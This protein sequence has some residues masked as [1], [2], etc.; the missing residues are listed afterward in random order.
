VNAYDPGAHRD[1]GRRII[2]FLVSL[3]IPGPGAGHFVFGRWGTGVGWFVVSLLALLSTPVTGVIGPMLFLGVRLVAAC[4]CVFMGRSRILYPGWGQVL[5]GWAALLGSTLVLGIVA[6]DM[7]L[8]D[9]QVT[10]GTMLPTLV[11]G[12]RVLVSKAIYGVRLPFT[13]NVLARPAAPTAGDLV[14]VR[15]QGRAAIERIVAVAGDTVAVRGGILHV[16]GIPARRSAPKQE[17]LE[18]RL[19][20]GAWQERPVDVVSESLGTERYDVVVD[21]EPGDLLEIPVPSGH[22]FVLSD[23]RRARRDSRALGPVRIDD[24]V[25][26]VEI[27][28]W[29]EGPTR[30]RWRRIGRALP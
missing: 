11:P 19:P 22:V 21:V 4:V 29:S 12:D 8:D 17:L 30:V 10:T 1:V 23:D 14:L 27:V 15:G 7:Y 20:S 3:T 9:V 25:G 24:L 26:K 13:G 5:V 2:G 28:W 18:D 6:R 16:N